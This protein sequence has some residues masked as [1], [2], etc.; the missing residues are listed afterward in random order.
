MAARAFSADSGLKRRPCNGSLNYNRWDQIN[1]ARID[2]GRGLCRH[3][4]DF[5]YR[6]HCRQLEV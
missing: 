4:S 6:V 2:D 5:A 1:D 3:L